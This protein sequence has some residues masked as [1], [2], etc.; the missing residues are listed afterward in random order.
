MSRRI[1]V[2]LVLLLLGACT[3]QGDRPA[4]TVNDPFE[5]TN[6]QIHAFNKGLDTNL[7]RPL[8]RAM[9]GGDQPDAGAETGGPLDIVAN[10]GGNLSLPGKVL[11]H[12]LQGRPEPAMRNGLRFVVNSTLGLGGMHDPA[13]A[14]FALTEIDTDFGETLYVWGLPEGPYLELPVLGP[15]TSRRAVG[16]VVD[17]AIDPLDNWLNRDQRNGATAIRLISKA[18]E[19]SRFG[20]TVDSVLYESADSYAQAR[21]IYLMHRHHELGQEGGTDDPYVI[22]P[23]EDS[24]ASDDGI[25]D[26][27]ED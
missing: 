6:R 3:A 16:R 5:S 14:E 9:D 15:S 11:N 22:D 18:G 23:Y 7:V 26:P 2:P 13:G 27:Y 21:L 12:I 1:H 10:I 8:T 4:Q 17:M 24:A 20:D 25:I 19:R